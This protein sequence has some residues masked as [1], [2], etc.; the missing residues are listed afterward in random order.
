MAI[1]AISHQMGA[2]GSEI[3]MGVAQRLG[4]HYVDQELLQD[5]VRRHEPAMAQRGSRKRPLKFFY[6]TQTGVSA[7]ID[8]GGNLTLTTADGRDINIKQTAVGSGAGGLNAA[9]AGASGVGKNN[10]GTLKLS[11]SENITFGGASADIGF[12]ANISKDSGSIATANVKTVAGA[13]D[14][15]SRIDAALST[16]SSMRSDLGAV[17]NR[18]SST[19]ANLQTISQN[20]SASRSQI[21][22]ADFAAETANMSSANILQQ[23]GVSVLAQANATTQSVLKLL[24]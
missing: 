7:S 14:T 5:A 20:L 4:Y 6:A 19:I 8:G 16:V 15:I 10:Q 24:Q 11:A 17:Q 2:G 13:N 12:S 23:A 21:L 9:Q 1:I 3:G 22:D 18:F